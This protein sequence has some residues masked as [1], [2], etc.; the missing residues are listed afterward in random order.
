MR[1]MHF[2]AAAGSWGAVAFGL[3]V[4]AQAAGF[5]DLSAIDQEVARFTGASTGAAGGARLPVDRRLKLA[6]C[7]APLALE[8]YGQR[9][10]TVLVRCPDSGG[11]R[12]YVPLDTGSPGAARQV[13]V[14]RGDAVT[15]AVQGRGFVLSRQA[16][17]LEGGAVGDWIRVRPAGNV[18]ADPIRMQILRPGT[19][20]TQL[21]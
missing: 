13:A 18:R 7:S 5:A 9:R 6:Q 21:P 8:W 1:L 19:V 15:I 3:S 10:D 2:I 20:G 11:W 4:P 12:I 16:E 17:A 14:A